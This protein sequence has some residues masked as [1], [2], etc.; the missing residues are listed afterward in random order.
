MGFVRL[1]ATELTNLFECGTFAED[2][3]IPGIPLYMIIDE[4]GNF[5]VSKIPF[6][7]L[8]EMIEKV[9]NERKR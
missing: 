6:E 4:K 9:L 7:N 2:Y 1:K 3:N 5:I 8:E